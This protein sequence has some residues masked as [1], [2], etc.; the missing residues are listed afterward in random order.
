VIPLKSLLLIFGREVVA[1][2]PPVCN[3]GEL[4]E[5]GFRRKGH[6][7]LCENEP[8]D[9]LGKAGKGDALFP[10]SHSR[11]YMSD[12]VMVRPAPNSEVLCSEDLI[13][14]QDPK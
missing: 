11:E 2:F 10:L 7:K 6:V 3:V 12:G 4:R 9:L 8:P 14:Y 1:F 13:L 5:V